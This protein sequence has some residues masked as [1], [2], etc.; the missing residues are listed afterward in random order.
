MSVKPATQVWV[1]LGPPLVGRALLVDCALARAVP[2]DGTDQLEA[3]RLEDL[4]A[5]L[6]ALAA[7]IVRGDLPAG[8]GAEA[9]GGLRL[10][11]LRSVVFG[12]GEA[13]AF[14]PLGVK[15]DRAKKDT[16]RQ[17]QAARLVKGGSA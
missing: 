10:R 2:D 16:R 5:F 7:C 1:Q 14:Q 4:D 6:G 13:A 9:L 17:R 15:K 3:G 11:E 8:C 12:I